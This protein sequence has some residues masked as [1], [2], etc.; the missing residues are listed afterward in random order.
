MAA[1][2]DDLLDLARALPRE[3]LAELVAALVAELEERDAPPLAPEVLATIEARAREVLAGAV[4]LVRA[5]AVLADG[6]A[7]L[8][9][10]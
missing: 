3:E 9:R 1:T 8:A 6:R 2:R 7:E 5:D 4:E 10:T